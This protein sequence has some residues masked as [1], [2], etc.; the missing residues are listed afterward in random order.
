M[1]KLRNYQIENAK[2]AIE[3]LS[4]KKIVYLCMEVRTG[5]TATAFETAKKFGAK[6]VLFLTKK[7]AIDSVLEDYNQ[8]GYF[9][10]FDVIVKNDES[11][12]TITDNDFDLVIHDEHH[13]YGSVPKPSKATTMFK[14]KYGHLPMIFLS[15]TPTPESKMQ[16]FHQFWVSQYSPFLKSN[17]YSFYKSFGFKTYQ[18]DLGFGM[19]NNYSASEDVIVKYYAIK[20]REISKQDFNYSLLTENISRQQKEDIKFLNEALLRL[21]NVVK[22]YLVTYTQNEAGFTSEIKETILT[23]KMS[24]ATQNISNRLIKDR[25]I[26]GKEEVV[27]ADTA[28]K[29]QSKLHQIHSGT[30]KFESGNTMVIDDSKGVFIKQHFKGKKIGI[31]YKF[32][33]EYDLLKSVFGEELTNDI[34]EFDE[35][36]KNIALQIVSGRE[37]ISLR[38]ADYLVFFNI[39][40]SATSYWQARDRMVTMDRL[41]NEVYWVFSEGG[42]ENSIYKAVQSKK[43]YTTSIFK[44]EYGI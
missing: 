29:L 19:V 35:T 37:G 21:D 12:H 24:K 16:W 30:V 43:S 39:D 23:V 17:F 15:G 13:R 14:V 32:K 20:R 22:D 27:L 1:K 7:K 10:S 34:T 11:M 31:F 3:I 8:F 33:A 18:F 41:N 25:V 26:N 36:S 40:F 44:K 42:I 6:K 4:S 28:V 2:K 9:D 38:K 5:K